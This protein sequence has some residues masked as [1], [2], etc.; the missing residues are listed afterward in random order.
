MRFCGNSSLIWCFI[1]LYSTYRHT[2]YEVRRTEN[3]LIRDMMM[4]NTKKHRVL[5]V[6]KLINSQMSMMLWDKIQAEQ[7]KEEQGDQVNKAKVRI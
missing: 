7:Q 3:F 4:I 5:G 2:T 1:I 6:T